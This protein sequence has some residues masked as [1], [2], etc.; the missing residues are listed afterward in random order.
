[1]TANAG[2]RHRRASCSVIAIWM[3]AALGSDVMASIGDEP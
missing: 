1:L 2:G 3:V